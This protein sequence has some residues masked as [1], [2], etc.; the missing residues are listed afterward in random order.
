[1]SA[2]SVCAALKSFEG[3][4]T[5]RPPAFSAIKI[6]G[7]PAYWWARK[8]KPV[9]LPERKV[10]VHRVELVG[11]DGQDI[12]C[13]V[14]CSAGTY[15]RTMAEDLAARLGTVGCLVGLTRQAVGTWQL[16]DAHSVDWIRDASLQLLEQQLQPVLE[17]E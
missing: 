8:D 2:E 15:V 12:R 10:Q 17:I 13:V 5:Q 7:K 11:F 1:L 6:K 16:S 14:V 3:E 9:D 4:Y